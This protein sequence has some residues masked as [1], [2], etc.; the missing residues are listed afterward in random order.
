VRV[1]FDDRCPLCRSTAEFL[2]GRCEAVFVPLESKAG[3]A[4]ASRVP[5]AERGRSIHV[6]LAD[7]TVRWG[8]DALLEVAGSW[9][10]ARPFARAA[11]RSRAARA[12]LAGLYRAVAAV[13]PRRG[14]RG[15]P[16]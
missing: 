15:P 7:G 9:P 10:A 14:A 12:A 6:E 3:R 11:S 4:I 13:R 8:V 2:R 1:A 16:V 5:A